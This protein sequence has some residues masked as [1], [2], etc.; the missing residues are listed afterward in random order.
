MA[1][2]GI[3]LLGVGCAEVRDPAEE[4][5]AMLQSG[6]LITEDNG[7]AMKK[8][9]AEENELSVSAEP[10]GKGAVRFI[11]S[12]TRQLSDANRFILV[13]GLEENPVHDSN[14]LWSRFF[15]T[16]RDTVWPNLPKGPTHFRLC[17]TDD[18]K[19]DA[20]AIYSKDIFIEVK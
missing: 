12:T 17:I 5:A 14:H 10:L 18:K 19:N 16:V 6:S 8:D 2:L 3:L 20:C 7:D 13:R 11:W 1:T 4:P 9:A 15:Y